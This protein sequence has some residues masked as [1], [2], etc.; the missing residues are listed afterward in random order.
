MINEKI[1]KYT[2]ELSMKFINLYSH[3]TFKK[4]YIVYMYIEIDKY[5]NKWFK[6]I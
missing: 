2:F 1:N 6:K 3:T 5:F 4:R